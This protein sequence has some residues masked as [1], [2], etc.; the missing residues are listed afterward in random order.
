[1]GRRILMVFLGIGAVAGFA[2]GFAH[3][4]GWCHSGMHGRYDRHAEFMQ[5]VSDTCTD[6]ALRVYQR[7]N[8]PGQKP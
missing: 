6:S 5:R 2:S 7:Q 4:G 3:L 1:M 8:G